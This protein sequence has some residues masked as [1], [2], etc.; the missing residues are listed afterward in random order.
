MCG[1][2]TGL[3]G[4]TYAV[5]WVFMRC[6]DRQGLFY[7][8]NRRKGFGVEAWQL[9]SL[10]RFDSRLLFYLPVPNV[11]FPGCNLLICM[12]LLVLRI[13]LFLARFLTQIFFVRLHVRGSLAESEYFVYAR[14]L[15]R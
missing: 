14:Y 6:G 15:K 13:G 3:Q 2:A 7:V 9:A 11:Y 12:L 10:L 4:F 8:G 1:L 5:C